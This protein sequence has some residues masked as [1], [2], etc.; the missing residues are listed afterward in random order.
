MDVEMDMS[1]REITYLIFF[2]QV[3][4]ICAVIWAV[5]AGWIGPHYGQYGGYGLLGNLRPVVKVVTETAPAPAPVDPVGPPAPYEMGYD[6]V[7]GDGNRHGRKE[8]GDD[9]GN[10]AG[11]YSLALAD[12]RRR[13]VEYKADGDG[14]RAIVKSN[15]P[16]TDA[17]QDPA[18][19]DRQPLPAA[20]A[21]VLKKVAVAAPV[22]TIRK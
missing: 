8:S 3:L 15:E 1:S 21:V 14:F 16:G 6:I 4:I 10:K 12:G 9:A 7:D 13:I 20:P 2:R 19:V 5:N 22:V 18:D 17:S 11:S